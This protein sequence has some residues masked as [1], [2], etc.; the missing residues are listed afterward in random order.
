MSSI[1]DVLILTR[2]RDLLANGEARAL[3]ERHNLS[4]QSVADA[5]GVVVQSVHNW[6]HQKTQPPSNSVAF[7]RYAMLLAELASLDADAQEEV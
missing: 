6:E 3:R 2:A 4:Q 1:D 7:R 5:V